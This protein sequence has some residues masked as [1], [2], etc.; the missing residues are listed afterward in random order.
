MKYFSK[1]RIKKKRWLKFLSFHKKKP[2]VLN[3]DFIYD[4]LDYTYTYTFDCP[5]SID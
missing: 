2:A 4:E 5:C 3:N 1:R